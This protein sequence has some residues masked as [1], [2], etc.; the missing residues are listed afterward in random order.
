MESLWLLPLL[1]GLVMIVIGQ[2]FYVYCA[3]DVHQNLGLVVVKCWFLKLKHF[4]FQ[5]A[6]G[7][8]VVRTEN[9]KKQV[10]Y[11]FSD[12]KLKF[13]ERLMLEI[14][15]K[16]KAKSLFVDA[17]V[18][19]NWAKNTAMFCGLTDVALKIL[20]AYVKNMKP[21]CKMH[22]MAHPNFQKNVLKISVYSKVSISIFDFLYAVVFAWLDKD[23][24]QK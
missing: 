1:F 6:S 18:G 4:S 13:Y 8:I 16:T 14:K 24:K 9:T 2:V 3:Y 20:C 5:I 21:T 19:A 7:G 15:D 23:K 11:A 12:P 17:E 10:N 22:A